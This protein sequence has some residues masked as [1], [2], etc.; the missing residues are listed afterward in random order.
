MRVTI[1]FTVPCDIVTSELLNHMHM[2]QAL[3]LIMKTAQ[4]M[5]EESARPSSYFENMKLQHVLRPHPEEPEEPVGEWLIEPEV[6][7]YVAPQEASQ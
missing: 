7:Q 4:T 5:L 6:T 3:T 2:D 1:R